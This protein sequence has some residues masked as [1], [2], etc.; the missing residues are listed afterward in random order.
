MKKFISLFIVFAIFTLLCGCSPVNEEKNE[1]SRP[2]NTGAEADSK[3]IEKNEQQRVV[4]ARIPIDGHI[5][6]SIN[7]MINYMA[8]ISEKEIL[9]VIF[10]SDNQNHIYI[11]NAETGVMLDTGKCADADDLRYSG[12]LISVDLPMLSNTVTVKKYDAGFD[13][14][15][16]KTFSGD[17]IFTRIY[18]LSNDAEKIITAF[19]NTVVIHNFET[20]EDITLE[21]GD[22]QEYKP[23]DVYAVGNSSF[24]FK[25]KYNEEKDIYCLSDYGG[26]VTETYVTDSD[27]QVGTDYDDFILI[28]EKET[29]RPSSIP[30]KCVLVD[31]NTFETKTVEFYSQGSEGQNV[32]ASPNGK[33]VMTR[34]RSGTS[35]NDDNPNFIY[36]IYSVDTGE[37]LFDMN[38]NYIIYGS[39]YIY[40]DEANDLVYVFRYNMETNE[41]KVDVYAIGESND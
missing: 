1:A 38:V 30:G 6:D 5:E 18:A 27:C 14:A 9:F 20:D 10:E 12:A 32:S 39:C 7:G 15:S 29:P 34:C 16:T 35:T 11:Y 2:N 21:Y 22:N 24:I 28:Y 26:N 36:R 37:M 19:S 17:G 23:E 4:S 40:I 33:Y 13:V 3:S 31:K 8:Y 41:K 25:S